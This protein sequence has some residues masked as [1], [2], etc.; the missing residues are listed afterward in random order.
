MR[1]FL[2]TNERRAAWKAF[3]AAQRQKE[4]EEAL[5][6]LSPA[7]RFGFGQWCVY[8]L[9]KYEQ[10]YPW[11]PKIRT[12][13]ELCAALFQR[14]IPPSPTM[15]PV[16]SSRVN[17]VVMTAVVMTVGLVSLAGLRRVMRPGRPK[18]EVFRD[19]HAL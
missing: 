19:M 17:A 1:R 2:S 16:P 10:V 9:P 12:S 6:S 3:E 13:K 14:G 15:E 4:L 8:G 18:R 7:K 11:D 5:D